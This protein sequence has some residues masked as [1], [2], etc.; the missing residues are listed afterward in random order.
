MSLLLPSVDGEAHHGLGKVLESTIQPVT[1]GTSVTLSKR[2]MDAASLFASNI[3]GRFGRKTPFAAIK[4]DI[5]SNATAQSNA[6]T[7]PDSIAAPGTQTAGSRAGIDDDTVI[8]SSAAGTDPDQALTVPHSSFL[9]QEQDVSTVNAIADPQTAYGQLSKKGR[10]AVRD[11]AKHREH[12]LDAQTQSLLISLGAQVLSQM[13]QGSMSTLE[14]AP[15]FSLEEADK[16]LH[17]NETQHHTQFGTVYTNDL[18]INRFGEDMMSMGSTKNQLIQQGLDGHSGCEA[19]QFMAK[20]GPK[21][22]ADAM[23]ALT[24]VELKD[25][26]KV[27]LVSGQAMID[28]DKELLDETRINAGAVGNWNIWHD[29]NE[30]DEK[31]LENVRLTVGG[32]GDTRT[33]LWWKDDQ[34]GEIT[35][36]MPVGRHQHGNTAWEAE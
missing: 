3:T 4:A 17:A 23:S 26:A 10:K 6:S 13:M 25:D 30:G 14:N 7:P 27:A 31:T 12:T 19:S 21:Y 33:Y 28:C 32:V 1:A 2:F 11:S 29:L 36:E 16:V 9:Q 15:R 34:T 20:K 35:V 5:A 24:D 18:Q 22:I 8:P